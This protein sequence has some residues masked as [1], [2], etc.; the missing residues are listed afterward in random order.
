MKIIYKRILAVMISFLIVILN[1][2]TKSIAT[3]VIDPNRD[4]TLTIK[5]DYKEKILPNVPFKI[6]RVANVSSDVNFELTGEFARYPVEVNGLDS[7]G[8][9]SLAETLRG[10]V[11]RDEISP[12][13]E[14][15]TDENGNLEFSH[16]G[17]QN[18]KPGMYLV[19]GDTISVDGYIYET[20]PFMSCLPNMDPIDYTWLYD[21]SVTPKYIREE[22]SPKE[23]I[24]I[25]VEVLWADEKLKNQRPKSVIINLLSDGNIYD[26]VSISELDDWCY[27]WNDIPKYDESGNLIVWSIV[28]EE[29][30]GYTISITQD[31]STFTV[32]NTAVPQEE[33]PMPQ[34]GVPWWP[35]HIFS[36][37]CTF[38][39]IAGFVI[40]R[41]KICR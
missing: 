3:G 10:Y 28:E 30:P 4:V 8:Y 32:L 39:L 14:G 7:S 26:T 40:I 13:C 27:M 2:V 29:I 19:I 37:C 1:S 6:Y 17:Q 35:I 25:Q 24:K 15:V 22:I 20:E 38:S 16:S 41:R 9:N 31:E 5:Y 34:T 11:Q 23:T 12:M 36:I 21:V 18:L 33:N